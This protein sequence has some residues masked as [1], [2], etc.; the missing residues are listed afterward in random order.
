MNDHDRD[1]LT[2]L[3]SID[4]QGFEQ[5]LDES[6]DDDIDY[7]IKLIQTY[8]AEL[9][10]REIELEEAVDAEHGLDLSDAQALLTKFRL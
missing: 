4:E 9:L 6:D 3:L 10:I 7:A 8:R 2:F 5:F 1:N